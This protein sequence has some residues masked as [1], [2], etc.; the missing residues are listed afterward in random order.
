MKVLE[1]GNTYKQI[2]CPHC[3]ALLEYSDADIIKKETERELTSVWL[4]YKY[5]VCLDCDK[6]IILEG[7]SPW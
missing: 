3:N 7:P 2:R 5:I 1:H 4:F 6:S